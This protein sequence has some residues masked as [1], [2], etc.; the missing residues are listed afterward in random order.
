M[1]NVLF[2]THYFA[3][4][5]GAAANRLTRLA[6]ALQHRGHDI[7]VLTTMP[8]YPRGVI[9]PEY[10]GRLSM[11]EDMDGIRV[12]RAW[13]WATPSPKIRARLLSQLSFMLTCAIRGSFLPRPDVIFVESQPIFSALAGWWVSK[14]KRRPYVI[15]ISD[16]WPEYLVV[17][18]VAK[19][20]GFTYRIFKALANLTQRDASGVVA[21]LDDLLAKVEARLGKRPRSRVIHNAVDLAL[22]NPQTDDRPFRQ[23]YALGDAR[24]ITFLGVLGPH[25]DLETML[26]AARRIQRDGV[27][28][29]FIGA[30]AQMKALQEALRQPDLA[31]CRHIEWVDYADVPG[32]WAASYIHFWALHHNEL[33]RMRFQAKLYEA[34]ASGTPTVIAVDGLMSQVLDPNAAGVTVP[35][36]DVDALVRAL[37]RLLDDPDYHGRI[38]QNARRYAEAHFD[39]NNTVD[40]YEALLLEV[41]KDG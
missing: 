18:G 6:R 36:A 41:V 21:M 20:S 9:P 34:L 35:P 39:P 12:I 5:A 8:H 4:D 2:I 1:M 28:F 15:N 37:E 30:G 19:E 26:A 27:Q 16:Y 40:A 7:S 10:R 31:H 14:M 22:F 25:I 13:L 32:F 11:V 17:S 3:P 33:D 23:K 24:Y 29:L 38:S